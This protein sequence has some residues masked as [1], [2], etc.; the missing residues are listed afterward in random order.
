VQDVPF[1]LPLDQ[2]PAP[3]EFAIR[4]FTSAISNIDNVHII[5][6]LC[7]DQYEAFKRILHRDCPA[8]IG[9]K[10]RR[11]WPTREERL[12]KKLQREGYKMILVETE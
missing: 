9:I 11:W 8:V 2:Q 6:Y 1:P 4:Q 10:K 12:A 5:P 7:R 3:F